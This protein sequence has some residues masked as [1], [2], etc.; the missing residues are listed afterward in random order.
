MPVPHGSKLHMPP[1]NYN[2]LAVQKEPYKKNLT[3]YGK[4]LRVC[5]KKRIR[6]KVESNRGPSAYQLPY[7]KAKLSHKQ[8]VLKTMQSFFRPGVGAWAK[9]GNCTMGDKKRALGDCLPYSS[10]TM[11]S[12]KF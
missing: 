6:P 8:K 11:K 12:C 2:L 4:C 10:D 7:R 1:A 3:L 9:V 5:C